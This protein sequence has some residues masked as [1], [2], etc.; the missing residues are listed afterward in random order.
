[1]TVIEPVWIGLDGQ[2][3]AFL[4]AAT[5]TTPSDAQLREIVHGDEAFPLHPPGRF[6]EKPEWLQHGQKLTLV[7]SG[8]DA[9][10]VAG[11]VAPWGQCL[12]GGYGGQC[13]RAP[14]SPTGYAAAMQGETLTAEGAIV[15][16]ANVGGG[17]NHAPITDAFGQRIVDHYANTASQTMRV[18]YGEDDYGIWLAGAVWP[19]LTDRQAA[20]I[21]ASAVSGDWRWRPELQA[22]DL[23]GVQL[24]SVPGYPLLRTVRASCEAHPILIGGMG[25][26]PAEMLQ[27]VIMGGVG[28]VAVAPAGSVVEVPTALASTAACSCQTTPG[29]D[30]IAQAEAQFPGLRAAVE[31]LVVNAVAAAM[32][33]GQ[34]AAPNPMGPAESSPGQ[35]PAE[36]PGDPLVAELD[37]RLADVEGALAE[38]A[39]RQ[40]ELEGWIA[41]KA[42]AEADAM[43]AQ[44]AAPPPRMPAAV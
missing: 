15:R 35:A 23:A 26:A 6:F 13:V 22:Y 12:L 14:R 16:T 9:G 3:L 7:A 31:Q 17:I 43:E 32:M 37:T 39:E 10:R 4:G 28:A 33:G 5:L 25:G 24:V 41:E 1:M 38:L 18:V 44:V 21:R 42:A 36:Q 29:D 30:V 2:P 8:A 11:Y 34:V 20:M 27:E 40:S 19:D